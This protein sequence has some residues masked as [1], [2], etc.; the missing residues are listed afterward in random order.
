M[1]VIAVLMLI[2]RHSDQDVTIHHNRSKHKALLAGLIVGILTGFLGIGGGFLVVPALV[3]FC[4][5]SM[6]DAVRTS[7]LIVAID[8]CA[9]LFGHLRYGG[10]DPRLTM[11]ITMVA[12][13]GTLI[14]TAL[15]H[16]ISPVNM[17]KWFATFVILVAIFLM[18]KNYAVLA[19]EL[20]S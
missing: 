14:G 5:I 9:G 12:I 8:C 15:S 20:P 6:K 18:G 13:N 19:H 1:I 2:K 11:L 4:G 7:L 16:H 17:K 10:F 3:L